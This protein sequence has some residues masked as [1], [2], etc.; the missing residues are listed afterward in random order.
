MR[1]LRTPLALLLLFACLVLA[2]ATVVLPIQQA[3]SDQAN[4]RDALRA[5]LANLNEPAIRQNITGSGELPH[6]VPLYLEAATPEEAASV[7]ATQVQS[8][9]PVGASLVSAVP[10]GSTA[11]PAFIEERIDV[12][13]RMPEDALSAFVTSVENHQPTLRFNRLSL[14]KGDVEGLL[15]VDAGIIAFLK[16]PTG[17]EVSP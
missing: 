9:V 14:R 16:L 4:E 12:A 3:F 8:L 7:L 11:T 10:A 13:L 6:V 1:R 5:R 17:S 2:A 15:L